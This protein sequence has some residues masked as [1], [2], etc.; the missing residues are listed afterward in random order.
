MFIQIS[1]S[2]SDLILDFTMVSVAR[3]SGRSYSGLKAA[4]M[5]VG[6][7]ASNIAAIGVSAAPANTEISPVDAARKPGEQSG[8]QGGY[9]PLRVVQESLAD[10]G[11]QATYGQISPAHVTR[12]NPF[13][14]NA[15]ED[16]L[17]SMPNVDIADEMIN[18]GVA[19]RAY[20]AS[21]KVIETEEEM[22]GSL[23]DALN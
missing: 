12:F 19:Q 5:T 13:D 4:S 3:S 14:P 2:V 18:L 22:S 17:V 15:N 7:A 16:G 21:L 1:E 9:R 8:D 11:V 23:L 20:E 6:A 10:G